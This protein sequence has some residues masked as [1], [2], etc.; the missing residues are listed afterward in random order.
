[1]NRRFKTRTLENRKGAATPRDT[2]GQERFLSAQADAFT[3]S[4]RGRKNR[5]APFGMTV[6]RWEPVK[7]GNDDG[8]LGPR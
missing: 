2:E 5:S 8:V 4:E 7:V 6:G 3:G 1:M